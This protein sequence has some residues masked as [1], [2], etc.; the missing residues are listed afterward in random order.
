MSGETV[1]LLFL[2][3]SGIVYA[4][5]RLGSNEIKYIER[6]KEAKKSGMHFTIGE[7]AVIA[8]GIIMVILALSNR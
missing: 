3:F 8:I 7:F 2:V 5:Y 6:K 4:I 1:I